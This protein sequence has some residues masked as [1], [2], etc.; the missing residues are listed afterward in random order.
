[1]ARAEDAYRDGE[2]S[3]GADS[4]GLGIVHVMVRDEGEGAAALADQEVS[5]KDDSA[6]SGALAGEHVALAGGAGR[7]YGT[8][9]SG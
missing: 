9:L 2:Q 4:R 8:E 6:P 5:Q 3:L 1:M 7:V